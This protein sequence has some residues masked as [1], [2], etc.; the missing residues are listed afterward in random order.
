MKYTKILSLLSILTI[1]ACGGNALQ[2]TDLAVQ[3]M[4]RARAAEADI[5]APQEYAVAEDLFNQMNTALENGDQN[6]AN[7]LAQEVVDAANK[8]TDV[9]RKNKATT[10]IAKLKQSLATAA[11]IGIDQEHPDIY[12]QATQ[13]LIDAENFYQM[14]DYEK[15]IASAQSGLDLLEPLIGGSE[16]LA[17]ANLNRA[18]E[19][20]DRAY[21]TTDLTQTEDQLL[22]ISN[23]IE[24]A[25]EE[26]Q[27]QQ[28]SDSIQSSQTAIDWLNEL[29]EKYPNDAA[30]SI[31]V[32]QNDNLQL[33]AY[34]L[35]RRLESVLAF[36]KEEYGNSTT[37]PSMEYE[38]EMGYNEEYVNDD[39]LE[40]FL[41]EEEI[42]IDEIAYF[43]LTFKAQNQNYTNT[44]EATAVLDDSEPITIKMI[45]ALYNSAQNYY[46]TGNYLNSIDDS[47]EGLRLADL[48]LANQTLTNHTVIKGDTLWDI[49]GAIYKTPWL[50]PNIWRANKLKIKDPDLIYPRQEFRIP[51][52]PISQ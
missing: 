50:W 21:K 38:E 33:Q 18:R 26:Y 30:I 2:P 52:A 10:L 9:A 39:E 12:A 11:S 4:E 41:Y 48:F 27:N 14:S 16:S 6:L 22:E 40:I 5:Y 1:V 42:E 23:L 46:N 17:L 44:M 35:L 15:A 37:P 3:A 24:Q 25:S 31:N 36:I 49:S 45:E 51:P 13:S 28:Y 32:N 47:R 7:Q 29:L 34:D 8:A 19:L 43:P 20:L